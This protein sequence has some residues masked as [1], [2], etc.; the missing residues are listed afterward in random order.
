MEQYGGLLDGLF[1]LLFDLHE[2]LLEAVFLAG[3]RGQGDEVT[4]HL[5]KIGRVDYVVHFAAQSHVDRSLNAA[6]EFVSSNTAGTATLLDCLLR[7]GDVGRI[8][9]VSTDE[10]YGDVSFGSCSESSPLSPRPS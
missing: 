6:A 9:H 4:L 8:L 2:V 1:R 3:E 10:V 7:H 5:R